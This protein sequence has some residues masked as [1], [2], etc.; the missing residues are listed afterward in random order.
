MA[1]HVH[2]FVESP[3]LGFDVAHEPVFVDNR[4]DFGRAVFVL[5]V[6]L[7]VVA[8]VRHCFVDISELRTPFINLC[9][10]TLIPACIATGSRMAIMTQRIRTITGLISSCNKI[11]VVVRSYRYKFATDIKKQIVFVVDPVERLHL[12]LVRYYRLI[13][14]LLI[15]VDPPM[16]HIV[17]NTI[18]HLI[19]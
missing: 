11:L 15:Q 14:S 4:V 10:T 19:I 17:L 8:Q 1:W 13:T 16:F 9:W 6:D 5:A 2:F 7:S 12:E 3:D 18:K